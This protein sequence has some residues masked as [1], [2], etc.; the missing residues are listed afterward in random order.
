MDNKSN[1]LPLKDVQKLEYKSSIKIFI[2][3]KL[4][5]YYSKHECSLCFVRRYLIPFIL[6]SQLCPFFFF[7]NDTIGARM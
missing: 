5:Y 2:N 1:S 4:E 3:F 7:F 6:V